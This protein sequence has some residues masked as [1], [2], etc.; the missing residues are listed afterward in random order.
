MA[1]R[2][3]CGIMAKTAHKAADRFAQLGDVRSLRDLPTAA[4]RGLFQQG[5]SADRAAD[6]FAQ[7]GDARS[8]RDLPTAGGAGEA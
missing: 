3:T 2:K 4:G 6:R 8:L 1:F 5:K 7:L